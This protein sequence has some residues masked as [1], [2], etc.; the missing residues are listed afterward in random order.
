[1][2]RR[3]RPAETTRQWVTGLVVIVATIGCFFGFAHI[4]FGWTVGISLTLLISLLV[5]FW[6]V[7]ERKRKGPSR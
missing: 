3:E 6:T 1:M 7:G 2:S 5:F 4:S